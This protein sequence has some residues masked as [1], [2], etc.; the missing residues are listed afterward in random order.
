M[1]QIRAVH[2]DSVT[3]GGG[4]AGCRVTFQVNA[5]ADGSTLSSM[6]SEESVRSTALFRFNGLADGGFGVGQRIAAV[7][8]RIVMRSIMC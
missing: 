5:G 7:V 4:W 3:I 8:A 2:G 6:V 1:F